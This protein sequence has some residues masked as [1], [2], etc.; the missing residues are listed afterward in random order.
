MDIQQSPI[1]RHQI[2]PAMRQSLECLQKPVF[3]LQT[4]IQTEA[5]SNPVLEVSVPSIQEIPQRADFDIVF[6]DDDGWNGYSDQD[7]QQDILSFFSTEKT[8]SQYL[9]DQLGEMRLVDDSLRRLTTYL[10]G[11]LDRRGY[12]DCS[13]EELAAERNCSVFDL[14]QA[15]YALQMLDPVGVGARDLSECLMLQLVQTDY[16]NELNIRLIQDG[17]PML[18][19]KD[20]KGLAKK[21]HVDILQIMESAKVIQGFNPIPSRGFPGKELITYSIPEAYIQVQENQLIVTLNKSFIPAVSLSEEYTT[22][23]KEST[24][25]ELRAYLRQK[26]SEA[27]AIIEGLESRTNTLTNL[28]AALVELQ[29]DF[30]LGGPLRPLTMQMMAERIGVSVST[31]SRAVQDKTIQFG[32]QILTLRSFFTVPLHTADGAVTSRD[33]IK[34]K[35]RAFIQSENPAHPLSD[36]AL[37]AAL[38]GVGMHVAR[39]TV[40][41]Y[42]AELGYDIASRR[43]R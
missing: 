8:F 41:K 43:V 2:S 34:Q 15:L 37:C 9:C 19:A 6:R 38:E 4:Y 27:S 3:E 29:R 35:L 20:Y 39:R 14:E 30:F 1:L 13:I 5:L 17:L 26:V 16:F 11:C 10:I 28:L 7:G 12:L 25:K 42:R 22:M 23:L 40:A 24:D 18:A 36:D 21:F 33:T 31:V 32:G